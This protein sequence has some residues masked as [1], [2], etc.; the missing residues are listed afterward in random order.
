MS[1]AMFLMLVHT[2]W[3][4]LLIFVATC[5]PT[6]PKNFFRGYCAAKCWGNSD[7]QR[8]ALASRQKCGKVH[9]LVVRT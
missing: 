3:A 1:L 9:F 4:W 6:I 5:G 8:P 7:R 2:R